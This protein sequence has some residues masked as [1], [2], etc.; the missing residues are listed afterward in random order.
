MVDAP[1]NNSADMN[2]VSQHQN[3]FISFVENAKKTKTFEKAGPLQKK[4]KGLDKFCCDKCRFSSRDIVQFH[5]HMWQHAEMTFSCSY[6]N[7][8]SY[9]RGESQRHLVK[10][11]G[12]FPFKCQFC[13][14]GA[15]RNDYIVKHTQRV[16]QV[17]VDKASYRVGKKGF[18]LGKQ[19]PHILSV[20]TPENDMQKPYSNVDAGTQTVGG[21]N[22]TAVSYGAGKK[23]SEVTDLSKVQVELLA[24]LNEPIQHDKPLTIAYPPEMTIPPGCF[25]EL[26]EV[27]TVNGTKELELKLVS[28]HSTEKESC[29]KDLG[30]NTGRASFQNNH[31]GKATFRCSVIPQEK[32]AI[33]SGPCTPKQPTGEKR[34]AMLT[35]K[36]LDVPRC[37]DLVLKNQSRTA[38]VAV[39]EEPVDDKR[40]LGE[41]MNEA[42][43]GAQQMG[44]RNERRHERDCKSQSS[45]QHKV[46]FRAHPGSVD[47][48]SVNFATWPNCPS[49]AESVK[50]GKVGGLSSCIVPKE[51]RVTDVPVIPVS[52]SV[53]PSGSHLNGKDSLSIPKTLGKTVLQKDN[54]DTH[55]RLTKAGAELPVIS[56]VF[57][58]SVGPGDFPGCLSWEQSLDRVTVK[59]PENHP[60]PS[61]VSL[62][63]CALKGSTS[64]VPEQGNANNILSTHEPT[65]MI[66]TDNCRCSQG[67]ASCTHA[68]NQEMEKTPESVKVNS[69]SLSC[70]NATQTELKNSP[71]CTVKSIKISV[72]TPTDS[73]S[74]RPHQD[75]SPG[76]ASQGSVLKISDSNSQ[77]SSTPKI[78]AG[79]SAVKGDWMPRPVL[80]CGLNERNAADTDHLCQNRVPKLSL[81]R[82]RSGAENE[83]CVDGPQTDLLADGKETHGWRLSKH[84][85]RRKK[86]K[87]L[88]IKLLSQ[89]PSRTQADADRL[90]LVPLKEDQP[91]KVPGPNQPVVVLN[92][93]NLHPLEGDTNLQNMTTSYSSF[94]N[95]SSSRRAWSI[96]GHSRQAKTTQQSPAEPDLTRHTLKMK[97]KKT[98]QNNYQVVGFI[99]GDFPMKTL[100]C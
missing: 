67:E 21:S 27:K 10:H 75:S 82:R 56:S 38:P 37:R 81:K 50:A 22:D 97:L 12:T 100:K 93:P 63:V 18:H 35:Q 72:H 62:E 85:K 36:Q 78:A 51:E 2:P 29:V 65:L 15:V 49:P 43:P 74:Q 73:R 28:Q 25:V 3:A 68:T 39:K 84:K 70:E 14:Y 99:Y 19:P 76:L 58:M 96:L 23:T 95:C 30:S 7:H 6:C 61:A 32:K 53:P 44:E 89:T 92:H 31:T 87:P 17:F 94:R 42:C 40:Q 83:S 47:G 71:P 57:S 5:K 11:T 52:D 13:P 98:H 59:K 48:G 90:W 4:T 54:E 8:V 79:R 69:P 34:D 91:V 41:T 9:T 24:P 20:S 64:A 45:G 55:P 88:K 77:S 86:H 1:Q 80:F 16:H 66:V 60:Q 46:P 33:H 26:V